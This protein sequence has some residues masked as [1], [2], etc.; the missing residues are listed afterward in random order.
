MSTTHN[1]QC[2]IEE[3][4][5]L[6]QASTVKGIYIIIVYIPYQSQV[7][8]R[9]KG[10]A[11]MT[12]RSAGPLPHIRDPVGFEDS[13]YRQKCYFTIGCR[14]KSQTLTNWYHFS[15]KSL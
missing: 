1:L 8:P 6:G 5:K 13:K 4:S 14:L 12:L 15:T 7:M 2:Y 11:C 9:L 10:T 3:R